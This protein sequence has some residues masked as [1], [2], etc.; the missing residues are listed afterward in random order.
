[1]EIYTDT[2]SEDFY[3]IIERANNIKKRL[4]E[5]SFN[6]Q[7]DNFSWSA[8]QLL[9]HLNSTADQYLVEMRS[10]LKNSEENS[11][12]GKWI[13]IGMFMSLFVKML[14]ENSTRKLKAPKKFIPGEIKDLREEFERFFLY[15]KQFLEIV[16]V[17]ERKNFNRIKM[18]SPVISMLRMTLGAGLVIN[19]FHQNRHLKQAENILEQIGK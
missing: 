15:Q 18:Y 9:G 7:P 5:V 8:G 12:T 1:M 6:K 3:K 11:P 19:I 10:V 4:D 17:K 16:E 13:T 2:L 14:D